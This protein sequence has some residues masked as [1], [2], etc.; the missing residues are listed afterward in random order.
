MQAF[1]DAMALIGSLVVMV[2]V[3]VFTYYAT[4]WYAGR[5]GRAISGQYIKIIDKTMIG[6][7]QMLYI[8]QAGEKY[9]LLGSGEKTVQLICELVDFAPQPGESPPSD[10]SFPQLFR[11]FVDRAK[12]KFPKNG[13]DQK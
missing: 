4:R 1:S 13:G 10:A 3:I 2:L 8:V 9:Y 11:D 12:T 7:G 6:P 5:M